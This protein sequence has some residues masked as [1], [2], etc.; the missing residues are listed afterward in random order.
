[1]YVFFNQILT[2]SIYIYIAMMEKNHFSLKVITNYLQS[3]ILTLQ[4]VSLYGFI[5]IFWYL[6]MTHL[7]LYLSLFIST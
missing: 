2:A 6:V 7:F 5:R 1:M 4:C 3:L